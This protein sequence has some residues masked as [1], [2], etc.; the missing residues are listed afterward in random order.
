MVG[1]PPET[2]LSLLF[3]VNVRDRANPLP[4][5]AIIGHKRHTTSQNPAIL[6]ALCQNTIFHLAGSALLKQVLPDSNHP[7]TIIRMKGIQP[8]M[9]FVFLWRLRREALPAPAF[10]NG[11]IGCRSP[12]HGG[13]RL[14][15]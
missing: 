3:F 8:T 14:D 15:Q 13:A 4:N 9:T 10:E 6:A 5:S 1:H 2:F 12:D 11:T 7:L